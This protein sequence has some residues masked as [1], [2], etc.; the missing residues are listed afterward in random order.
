MEKGA[1][2]FDQK[3]EQRIC[4]SRRTGNKSAGPTEAEM[5][6]RIAVHEAG[7]CFRAWAEGCVLFETRVMPRYQEEQKKGL[8]HYGSIGTIDAG[9]KTLRDILVW[10]AGAEA[11]REIFGDC[12]GGQGDALAIMNGLLEFDRYEPLRKFRSAARVTASAGGKQER[13]EAFFNETRR[14]L[15]GIKGDEKKAILA[16]AKMLDEKGALSGSDCAFIL[17]KSFG[18]RP[19]KAIPPELHHSG[20]ISLTK[21]GLLLNALDKVMEAE[22]A[23]REQSG[24]DGE[25]IDVL[26]PLLN[27]RIHLIQRLKRGM[28]KD[29]TAGNR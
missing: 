5:V 1:S 23:I 6:N 4:T 10:L 7:H 21:T 25:F 19:E 16:L 14:M 26:E 17:E 12:R 27:C 9:K 24:D 13:A 2:T 3:A 28:T 20:P 15:P 22:K 18:R 11:E 8:C 29:D